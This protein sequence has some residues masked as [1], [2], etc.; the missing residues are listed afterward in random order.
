M[1]VGRLSSQLLSWAIFSPPS[2]ERGGRCPRPSG[3]PCAGAIGGVRGAGHRGVPQ[4]EREETRAGASH[5][6]P[7]DGIRGEPT[8]PRTGFI[9]SFPG[10]RWRVRALGQLREWGAV[11]TFSFTVIDIH[12]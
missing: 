4:R 1:A 9:A 5:T 11:L 12:T 3:R 8:K 2:P 10:P 7:S 6:G